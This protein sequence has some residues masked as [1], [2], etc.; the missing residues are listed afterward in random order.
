MRDGMTQTIIGTMPDTIDLP[1]QDVWPVA[2]LI[3]ALRAVDPW[4]AALTP[5]KEQRDSSLAAFERYAAEMRKACE[6]LAQT[7]PAL[8]RPSANEL[9][10]LAN[11]LLVTERTDAERLRPIIAEF[12]TAL[13]IHDDET[14]PDSRELL[15]DGIKIAE[16]WLALHHEIAE[17][18]LGVAAER[19]AAG[20]EILRARP[21]KGKVDH[22]ALSREF[23]A[24]FPKIRAALAK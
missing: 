14:C 18:L 7:D 13:A 21:V 5:I 8:G 2:A 11:L 17:K 19:R 3:G 4:A 24:R 22:E 12:R 15:Q 1:R 16:D 6:Q 23:M 9:T 20:G 10:N